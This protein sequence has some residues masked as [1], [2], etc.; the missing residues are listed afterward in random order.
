MSSASARDSRQE[1]V[2][3]LTGGEEFENE[4]DGQTRP[5]NHWLPARICGSTTMRSESGTTIV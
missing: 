2:F 4:L 1:L 3:G 5:A